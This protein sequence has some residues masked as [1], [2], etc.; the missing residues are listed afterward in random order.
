[1]RSEKA[2]NNSRK[3]VTT[4]QRIL[5]AAQ[6]ISI[7]EQKANDKHKPTD[8]QITTI[9][10]RKEAITSELLSQRQFLWNFSNIFTELAF[11]VG[12]IH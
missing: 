6:L 8:K 11:K 5:E 10:I 3:K 1:M 2:N 4:N 9:A 12:F 7:A